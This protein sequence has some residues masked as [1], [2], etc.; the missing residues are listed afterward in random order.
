M[1]SIN[2]FLNKCS[3]HLLNCTCLVLFRSRVLIKSSNKLNCS[4]HLHWS[5][6]VVD[7]KS[8]QNRLLKVCCVPST[9]TS[10]QR[11]FLLQP[12]AVL[13][14]QT[15][16]SVHAIN[17][18]ILLRCLWLFCYDQNVTAFHRDKAAIQFSRMLNVT[19]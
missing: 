2:S 18:S 11:L 17:Q 15:R 10:L 4:V 1:Q 9:S 8:L 16:Q 5:V 7:I 12:L 14:K 6:I 13:M 19:F 3:K